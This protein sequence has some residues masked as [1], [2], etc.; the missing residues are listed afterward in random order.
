MKY[1]DNQ[2]HVLKD[3]H[4]K[5]EPTHKVRIGHL[6]N[7]SVVRKFRLEQ[8]IYSVTISPIFG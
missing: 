7:T 6:R 2:P 4:L 1:G 3:L 5:I 8:F